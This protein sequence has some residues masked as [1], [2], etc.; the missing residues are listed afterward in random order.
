ML[1]P[2]VEPFLQHLRRELDLNLMLELGRAYAHRLCR[3]RSTRQRH[4]RG[5]GSRAT[6]QC[7]RGAIR[8]LEKAE[9]PLQA[10]EGEHSIL[11]EG[12]RELFARQTIDLMSAI[13]DEVEHEAELAELVREMT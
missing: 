4:Q 11:A 7:L 13:R 12:G 6:D 8:R 1:A 5:I 3:C 9:L 2:D 10:R